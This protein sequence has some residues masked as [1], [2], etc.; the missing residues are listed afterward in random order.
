MAKVPKPQGPKW[1][2]THLSLHNH[3]PKFSPA[4]EHRQ[5]CSHWCLPGVPDAWKEI[6]YVLGRCFCKDYYIQSSFTCDMMVN[7]WWT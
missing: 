1:Q 7:G 5:D 6:L 3:G 4:V 2:F